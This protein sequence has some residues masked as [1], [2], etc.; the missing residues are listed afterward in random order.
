MLS[1][2]VTRYEIAER[3][4]VS[5]RTVARYLGALQIA[6]EPIYDDDTTGK[7]KVWRLQAGA[8][9]N[10]ITMTTQQMFALFLSRRVFDFLSET[11]FK[12]D[13]DDVFERLEVTLK[14]Q[15]YG[16]TR[17]FALKIHDVNE[18]PHLYE[19]R[20]E[21]VGDIVNA[22][23]NNLRMRVR[24]DSIGRGKTSFVVESYT[25]L[26]YKKGLYLI[27]RSHHHDE[28]RTVPLDGFRSTEW[29]KG[30]RLDYPADYD[31]AKRF[32][33][34]FG[35][36][37]GTPE[38]VRIFFDQSVARFVR[39]RQWHPSQHI[40]KVPDG[41]ELTMTVACTV[42]VSSW[43]LSFGDKAVVLEPVSLRQKQ[44]GELQ[45]AAKAYADRRPKE[46]SRR[47]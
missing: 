35:L 10:T 2:G 46:F 1:L 43:I 27:C 24:H 14:N 20:F 47:R 16:K 8:R 29:L 15:D 26:I 9:T 28:I 6:E 19:G 41:V 30:E 45:R 7:A 3:L 4:K 37:G 22:L 5:P 42:E 33:G 17:D 36:F 38:K 39:R 11:G 44:R 13:L 21:D 31:P 23:I 34:N 40:T 12:E 25:L 32:A 18:A